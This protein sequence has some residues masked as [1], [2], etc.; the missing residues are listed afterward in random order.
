MAMIG[1]TTL[2]LHPSQ[3]FI[4]LA[5]C[6]P[7]ATTFQPRLRPTATPQNNSHLFCS[8]T[9]K[10]ISMFS[11]DTASFFGVFHRQSF[12]LNNIQSL[13]CKTGGGG[14]IHPGMNRGHA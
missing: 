11:T 8:F 14:Y 3:N 13:F 2:P 9:A 6:P 10:T 5:Y 4:P 12:I 1:A 7:P